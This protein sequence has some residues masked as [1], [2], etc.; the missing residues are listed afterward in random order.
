MTSELK[1]EDILKDLKKKRGFIKC[2]LTNFKKY[3]S[4]FENVELSVHQRAEL[5]LRIPGAQNLLNDFNQVQNKLEDL[6]PAS[7]FEKLIESRA[8]FEKEYYVVLG[9][10]DCMVNPETSGERSVNRSFECSLVP[11]CNAHSGESVKLP[12]ISIPSFDGSN[13]HWIEFRDTF[14]SLIH[15]SKTIPE[16]QKFHYLKASLKGDA[17]E[18]IE[19]VEFSSSNYHVA[20]EL[21]LHRFNNTRLI[22]QSHIKAIFSIPPITKE[23]PAQLNKLIDTI[24]K[25]IRSLKILGEPTESWDD[26]IIFIVVSKLDPASERE[27]EQYKNTYYKLNTEAKIHLSDLL[28]FLKEKADLLTTLTVSHSSKISHSNFNKKSNYNHKASKVHCNF[29]AENSNA[30]SKS[31]N[32]KVRSQFVKLCFFCNGQHP[33]YSCQ[34]FLDLSAQ[35]KFNFIKDKKLCINCMRFGHSVETCVFGACRKCDLK[36]NSLI[37]DAVQSKNNTVTLTTSTYGHGISKLLPPVSVSDPSVNSCCQLQP[38][39]NIMHAHNDLYDKGDAIFHSD[40][41]VM[42]S[43]A[44]VEVC[45]QS[46]GRPLTAP[47]TAEVHDVPA[48]CL[49]RY[50]RLEQ[51]RQHFWKRW[52]QEYVSELQTRSKWQQNK[53]ALKE[54]ML[55]LIKDDHLPPMKWNALTQTRTQLD[56]K[57]PIQSVLSDPCR[58]MRGWGKSAVNGGPSIPGDLEV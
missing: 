58:R 10:L 51:I 13:E 49:T 55:V 50:Q 26:L 15:N 35:D 18:V 25:N 43:T 23:S 24:L 29:T 2:R 19:N 22:I 37:C 20:W 14:M 6:A 41:L 46:V 12:T 34:K 38:H 5:K 36:H 28:D 52:S 16:I 11:E 32:K 40:Q 47:V 27:W 39:N 17:K 1:V 3:V 8:E 56:N 42:L 9:M 48:H 21:L 54:D 53:G 33:L 31:Q 45:G 57:N 7:E 30:N 44:M 4:S